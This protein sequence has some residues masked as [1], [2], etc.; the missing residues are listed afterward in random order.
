[1]TS[2]ELVSYCIYVPGCACTD[3]GAYLRRC[4]VDIDPQL[5]SA[6]IVQVTDRIDALLCMQ[7]TIAV[8]EVI[9]SSLDRKIRRSYGLIIN[10]ADSLLI[11]S[12]GYRTPASHMLF[13][14]DVVLLEVRGR[15]LRD[16][17]Y[18]TRSIRKELWICRL[19]S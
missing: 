13:T 3:D 8:R 18:L 12:Q 16:D 9:A 5:N 6:P 1:M 10:H 19:S 11:I 17:D 15:G 14:A 2:L 4:G 7:V